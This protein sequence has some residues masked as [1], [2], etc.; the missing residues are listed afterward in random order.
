MTTIKELRDYESPEE[1][2]TIND[3]VIQ[4]ITENYTETLNMTE[5]PVIY[6]KNNNN[7][8]SGTYGSRVTGS[9]YVSG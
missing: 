9:V 8:G 7:Y 6:D 4:I 1:T 5:T 3:V 2:I